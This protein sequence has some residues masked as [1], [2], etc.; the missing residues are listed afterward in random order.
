M[1]K[2]EIICEGGLY[3]GIKTFL[4]KCVFKLEYYFYS[5]IF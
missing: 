3:M 4:M 2:F 1:I 5:E